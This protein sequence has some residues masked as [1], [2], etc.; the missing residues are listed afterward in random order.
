MATTS[1][2]PIKMT[3]NKTINYV[4]DKDKTKILLSDLSNTIDYAENK[5]K[6]EEQFY[7]TGINCNSNS[8][9]QDMMR[10]KKAYNKLDRIQGFH[11]YQSFKEG[12][13]T[14]ELAHKIGCELA[15]EM[16]GDEFQEVVAISH[17]L[18]QFVI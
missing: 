3:I 14:P 6:T 17:L 2:W 7:I 5:N 8:V 9:Y 16:W 1:L 13:V 18:I 12:E 10:V 4:E 11:R 15:K